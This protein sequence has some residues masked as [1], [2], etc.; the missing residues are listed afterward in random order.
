MTGRPSKFTEELFEA[1]CE[2]VAQG[3]TLA[4]ICREPG[5]PHP[6]TFRDWAN[7]DESLSRRFGRAREDG[8]DAIAEKSREIV[9]APAVMTLTE[10]GEKVDAGDVA[11][12][13]VQSEHLLKLLAKFNP[14]RWGDR[15]Q[16]EHT[17]KLTLEAL[18]TGGE[19]EASE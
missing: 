9:L 1:I 8:E 2:R 6:S 11:L 10:H 15:T 14:K 4:A 16:H 17:G 7:S 18:V 5:M 12:R 3:E 19:A 13:K